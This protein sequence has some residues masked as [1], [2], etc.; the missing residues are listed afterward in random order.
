MKKNSKATVPARLR[1]PGLPARGRAKPAGAMRRNASALMQQNPGRTPGAEL[2]VVVTTF[3]FHVNPTLALACVPAGEP[4]RFSLETAAGLTGVH[5]E[6]LRYYCRIGLL[7]PELAGGTR[8]P[9]FDEEALH[10]VRRIEHYRRHL[11][12]SRQALPL[13]CALRRE[14]DRRHIEIHFLRCP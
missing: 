12:V 8:E 14:A 6:L 5:P 1:K 9:A 7:G 4:V 3:A 13:V 10:E 11:A 2:A